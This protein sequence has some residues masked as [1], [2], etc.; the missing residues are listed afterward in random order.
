M[1]SARIRW[2][3]VRVSSAATT[4][5]FERVSTSRRD[6]SPR[7]PMGVAARTIT[8]P[9]WWQVRLEGDP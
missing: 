7:L 2:I 3:A 5:A 8:S 9:L 4:L 6:A 1:P